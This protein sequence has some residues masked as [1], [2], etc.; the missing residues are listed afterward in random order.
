[1]RT[2]TTPKIMKLLIYASG[3]EDRR[4]MLAAINGH[5]HRCTLETYAD[6]DRLACR[7]RKSCAEEMWL[8]LVAG[9]CEELGEFTDLVH[10]IQHCRSILVL[11]DRRHRT[12][13]A[14][15][16]LYPRYIGYLDGDFSDIRSVLAQV[17]QKNIVNTAQP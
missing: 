3:G 9:T 17:F 12:L 4:R 15:H 7:L 2:P 10:L 6:L 11:P 8:V 5:A 14:A 13:V 16:M 1:M